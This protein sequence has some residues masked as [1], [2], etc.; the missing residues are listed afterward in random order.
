M[1]KWK[2]NGWTTSKGDAVKN[3]D[4]WE[5]FATLYEAV[6]EAN[7]DVVFKKVKGHS[8]NTFNEMADEVAR[9]RQ[10]WQEKAI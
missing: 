2:K 10:F 5:D 4:L 9:G 8:G 7:I 1:S 6:K 3:R